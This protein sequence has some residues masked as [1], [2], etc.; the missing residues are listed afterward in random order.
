MYLIKVHDLQVFS[1][2]SVPEFGRTLV[3]DGAL[4]LGLLGEAV[5][6]QPISIERAHVIV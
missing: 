5:L 3:P 4:L 1:H 6:V 2:G